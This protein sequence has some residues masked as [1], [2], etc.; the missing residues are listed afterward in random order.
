MK[1]RGK[2]LV[3]VSMGLVA[4]LSMTG[5]DSEPQQEAVPAGSIVIALGDSLTYGYGSCR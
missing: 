2:F 1:I 3:L 5:C 4:T